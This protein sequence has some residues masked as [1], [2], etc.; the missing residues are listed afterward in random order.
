MVMREQV[1]IS[2]MKE[3][4]T[5]TKILLKSSNVTLEGAQNYLIRVTRSGHQYRRSFFMW[6][7]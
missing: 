7:I 6:F 3:K 1:S 2:I 5:R 4:D